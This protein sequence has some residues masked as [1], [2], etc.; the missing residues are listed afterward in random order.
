MGKRGGGC[1]S[2]F[3]LCFSERVSSFSLDLWAIR[4]SEF[5]GA[6]RKVVLRRE[7]YAWAPVLGSFDKLCEVGFYPTWFYTL[8]KCFMMFR[9]G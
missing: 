8:F 6:R 4:P 9:L 7:T 1:S 5:F 2:H 3:F